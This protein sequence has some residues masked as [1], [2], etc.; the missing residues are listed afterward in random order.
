MGDIFT[1][2]IQLIAKGESGALIAILIGIIAALGWLCRHLIK[3][4]ATKD[5]KI[6]K[7]VEDYSKNNITMSE[8]LNSIKLVLVEI[9]AKL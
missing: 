1:A 2:L 9:K 4:N 3:Q 8:A 5:E 6:Y 7:I